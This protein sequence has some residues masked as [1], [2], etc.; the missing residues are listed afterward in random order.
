MILDEITLHNFGLYNGRQSI[1]LTPA[2][3][4]K[5]VILFGGLNGGGKTTLLDALQLCLFGGHAKTS[6][7]GSLAYPEYLARCIHRGSDMQEAGVRISFRHTV[8]GHEECYVIDRSWRLANG[9][10]KE[11]FEVLKN[12]T[13]DPALADNW[14]SQVD[15]FIPANIAHLFLFD[16]EQIERYASQQDSSLLIG[17]AIQN[18]LGLDMVDQLD[19]DLQVYERRK[20]VQEKD[21]GAQAEI[22]TLDKELRE[23]RGRLQ[24]LKLDRASLRT[25]QI[26]RKQ[27]ERAQIEEKY[28]KLGGDL[29]DQRVSIEERLAEAEKAVSANAG[30][31]REL[32]SGALPLVMVKVLLKSA[33]ARDLHEEECHRARDVLDTLRT[34]DQA[35]LKRMRTQFKDKRVGD[36]LKA[37]FDDD[38]TQ[39]EALSKKETLLDL[40]QDVRSDIHALL[41][42]DI[43]NLAEDSEKQLRKHRKLEA[44]VRK[45]RAEHDSIPGEDAIAELAGK[46]DAARSEIEKLEVQHEHMGREIERLERDIERKEQSLTRLLE[47]DAVARRQREDQERILRHSTR[48]RT[49]LE[50]FRGAVIA[51][52]VRRIE[53]LVLESY[54]QLLRKASLVTRLS[55]DPVSYA[56]TLYGRDGA[57]LS[58]E[59]L[60]AGERQLLAIALLWGLAKASGRPLPTAIDTPLGRLDTGHR[61]HLVERYLPFASHQVL[62]FS[63]DEEIAGDYLERLRPWIGRT[64]HLMYNDD[65]GSTRVV[66]GY[67]A[68]QEAA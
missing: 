51:R 9:S 2:S 53:Q 16:G 37:F 32:A 48:V 50:S 62:L 55:I 68:A 14:A 33:E 12:G 6:S 26:D 3:Q 52:H 58:P 45:A 18:L 67:F 41:R 60:S 64:Y 36:T 47:R 57:A 19:K 38:R 23:M 34:R 17:T 65:Q 35:A 28:R 59:R 42:G 10:C 43:D 39:R 44:A 49:T 40:S 46:R 13:L 61:I 25:H 4:D 24:S 11:R 27:R 54:Q 63:T 20:R 21:Q 8:D 31:L 56:L 5:P 7:R 66:P 15:D 1:T 22:A 30:R 29:Y